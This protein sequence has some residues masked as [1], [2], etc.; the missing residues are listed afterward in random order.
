MVTFRFADTFPRQLAEMSV[1]EKEEQEQEELTRH[2]R[3]Y[4]RHREVKLQKVKDRYHNRPEVMARQGARI[5]KQE[6]KAR[7]AAEKETEKELKKAERVQRMRE[8]L[9]RM[10]KTKVAVP[11]SLRSA[12]IGE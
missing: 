7:L 2:Q 10:E 12:E 11:E 9:E 6:E 3:H 8:R 1:R 4:A 5:Q